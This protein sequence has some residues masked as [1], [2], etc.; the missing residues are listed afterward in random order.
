LVSISL[1]LLSSS[2][3][4]SSSFSTGIAKL[5]SSLFFFRTWSR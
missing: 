5:R 3:S 2:S 1:V 4:S